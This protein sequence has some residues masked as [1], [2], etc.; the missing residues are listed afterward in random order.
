[1]IDQGQSE[2]GILDLQVDEAGLQG[3]AFTFGG[4]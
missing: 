4:D 3:Y 2:N 1:L